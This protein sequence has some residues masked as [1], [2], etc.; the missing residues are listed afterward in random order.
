LQA[1]RATGD[2]AAES[3]ALH[4]WG[5]RAVCMEEVNTARTC[6]IRA[7]RLRDTLGDSQGAVVT[8]HN[9][10][11]LLGPPRPMRPAAP[12]GLGQRREE[13][14]AVLTRPLTRDRSLLALVLVAAMAL[15]A[16]AAVVLSSFHNAP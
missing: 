16:A 4:Q 15:L 12:P 1:A 14:M 13:T 9:L 6:L 7:L 5:S 2:R 11:L 8:R 3:Y 10:Q